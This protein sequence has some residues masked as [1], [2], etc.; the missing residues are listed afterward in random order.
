VWL[1]RRSRYVP[2]RRYPRT[3]ASEMEAKE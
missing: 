3:G 2:K 1:E